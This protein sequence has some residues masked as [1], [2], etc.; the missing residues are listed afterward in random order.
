MIKIPPYLKQG[1]TIG[2]TCPAGYMATD[3]AV[4]CIDTLQSWGYKVKVGSTLGSE[5][6]NYFSADDKVR[7]EEL[8][9][10]LDDKSIKA[11]LF[12]RGGYGMSRIIDKIDLRK[13]KK[14]PKW[15][16]GFSDITVMHTHLLG[17]YSIASMHA[18]MA[19]AFNEGEHTNEYITSLKNALE[20]KKANYECAPHPFNKNGKTRGVLV[21]GNLALLAHVI[22][23]D[24]DFETKNRILFLE[25][26]GEYIYNADR[27]LYQLKRSG[28]FKKIAGL[29]LGG[30]TDMKDTERPFGKSMDEILK[31]FTLAL[32]CPV[33]FH[34]PVS[35]S[36][37]NMALKIGLE[38]ELIVSNERTILK[39]H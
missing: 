6:T 21:G 27:M 1:D 28:K 24:S 30:F 2:I 38:Y 35:H 19:A 7:A 12:G 37:E 29:V 15:I 34:F 8:Q 39:E 20:G 11:I 17:Y 5:S 3:K 22:G 23:T 14:I 10:M 16:I 26:I 4:A 32:K 25:D 18:P 31:D 33:C 36:K 9:N 13:F